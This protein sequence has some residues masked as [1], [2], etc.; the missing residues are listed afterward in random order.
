MIACRLAEVPGTPKGL[1]PAA[2]EPDIATR[3]LTPFAVMPPGARAKWIHIQ[4][5]GPAIPAADPAIITATPGPVG[6]G[7]GRWWYAFATQWGRW[8]KGITPLRLGLSRSDGQGQNQSAYGDEKRFLHPNR[9]PC[10]S[11]PVRRELPSTSCGETSANLHQLRGR[12]MRGSGR[13]GSML[14]GAP[15]VDIA[16]LMH[17]ADGATGRAAL[18]GDELALHVSRLISR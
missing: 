17:A 14:R 4:A 3:S 15:V 11:C 7:L 9:S 10:W 1:L 18:F 13:Y 12:S 6:M 2:F 8:T 5:R 16:H